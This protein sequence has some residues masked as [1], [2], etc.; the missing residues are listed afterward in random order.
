[1]TFPKKVMIRE[2]G[3]REGMQIE[4]IPVSTEDKIRIVDMLSECNFPVI[5]VTSF[6]SPKWVPEMADAEEVAKGF[7]RYPGTE[8]QCVYLNAKG[9]ERAQATGKFDLEGVLSITASETFSK[10]NTNLLI[11]GTFAK[12]DDR[13][14]TLHAFNIPVHTIAVMT[15]FG[16]TYEGDTDP[17]HVIRL[18]DR[19]M[20]KA[21]SFGENPDRILLGDTVGWAN[22][23]STEKLVGKVQDRWPDKDIILHLHDTRG[24]GMA[25]AYIGLK[26]GVT[27]YDSSVGGLGGCPFSGA[28]RAAGNIATED[29]VHMCN[30]L[31]IPTGIDLEKLLEVTEEIER[32]LGRLLPSKVSKGGSLNS[33]RLT[34][35]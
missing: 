23:V 31:G 21:K 17:D 16:C 11:E 24:M 19:S 34:M 15:A 20:E 33:Y 8:Y 12:M 4:K 29:L 30:E 9:I 25:N 28:G 10:R 26:M 18:I 6:V 14:D 35:S 1:M 7:T 5:E 13:M 32:I 2:V 3:P 22:P 27:H